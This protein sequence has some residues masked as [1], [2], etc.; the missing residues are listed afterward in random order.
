MRVRGKGVINPLQS[1]RDALL[2]RSG[3]LVMSRF[4]Q[5]VGDLARLRFS[6]ETLQVEP[7]RTAA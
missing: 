1:P 7:R 2:H 5:F 3:A 4:V 6:F